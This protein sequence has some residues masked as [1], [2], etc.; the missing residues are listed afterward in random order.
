M[1]TKGKKKRKWLQAA[2][3]TMEAKGTVGAFTRQAKAAG[4]SVEEYAAMVLRPGSKASPR[5]KKRAQFAR[6][7]GKI[8][9]RKKAK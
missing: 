3:R 5:T 4:M 7:A 8:G 9:R 1:A 2:R 6:T